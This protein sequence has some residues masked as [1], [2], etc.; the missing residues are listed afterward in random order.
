MKITRIN[1]NDHTASIKV[2]RLEYAEI[3]YALFRLAEYYR[4]KKL[5]NLADE[6]NKMW[7]GMDKGFDKLFSDI[8]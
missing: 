8:A 6:V 5:Y 4:E 1:M 7:A 2:E 3:K